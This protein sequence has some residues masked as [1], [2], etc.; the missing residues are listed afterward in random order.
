LLDSCHK[1][2][3]PEIVRA[4]IE[5]SFAKK[6][7]HRTRLLE[8]KGSEVSST[9]TTLLLYQEH[10]AQGSSENYFAGS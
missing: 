10:Y 2:A 3:R 6:Q 8:A 9:N 1:I 5:R 4:V 7:P